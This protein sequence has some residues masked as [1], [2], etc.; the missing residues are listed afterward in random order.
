MHISIFSLGW[1]SLLRDLRTGGLRLMFAA[2]ALA[3]AALSSVAFFADRLNAGLQRDAAQ[4]LGGDVVVASDQPPPAA[5]AAQAQ[6]WGLASSQ[7]LDFPT[8][9]RAEEAH[10]GASRLVAL[11]SVATGYPLRGQLRSASAPG[12]P[13]EVSSPDVPAP[14]QVW[15]DAALPG[16]LG[17]RMGDTLLLGDARLQ[18]ARILTQEPDRGAGFMNFAPRVLMNVADLPATGLVQPASRITYRFAVAGT[19]Q[20][21]ARFARWA[22]QYVANAGVRGLRVETLESGSPQMRQTLERAQ[23]FLHLV[24]LLAALLCAVAVALAARNFANAH[25]D[26]AALLR[27]LGLGQRHIAGAYLVEFVLVGLAASLLGLALGWGL[28]HAFAALLADLVR[29]QLPAPGLWPV[30][31]GLG[32]GLT[33]L[34]AFGLPPVLLSLIHI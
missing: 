16:A 10:G 34:C 3:V 17:L 25:L 6:A 29:A 30:A 24:A 15:V 1:R 14:G 2:V 4:L 7:T 31:L 8:M 13:D 12:A 9:A 23:K 27:V 18:V 21:S 28:H 5:F 11:K 32:L 33:L 22:E 20:D 19:A 26:G